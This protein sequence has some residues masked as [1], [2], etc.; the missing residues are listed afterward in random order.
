MNKE[1]QI[2][3]LPSKGV[4]IKIGYNLGRLSDNK[5]YYHE[6]GCGSDSQHLYFLSDENIKEG[7]WVY[8]SYANLIQQFKKGVNDG[9]ALDFLKKIIATTDRSLKIHDHSM[10]EYGQFGYKLLPKPSD[11][12]LKRYCR[13]GG[14]SLVMV[15]YQNNGGEKLKL[16][17]NSDNTINITLL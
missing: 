7:D 12:F 10:M 5:L 16:K 17:V 4:V 2:V 15:E 3:M 9:N 11:E 6:N 1:I 8:D 13:L 14:T